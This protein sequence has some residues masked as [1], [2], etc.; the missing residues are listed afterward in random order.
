[1]LPLFDMLANAQNGR[2][3]ELIARQFE[4]NRQQMELAM[5][6]LLPAFSVGLKR[7]VSDPYGVGAF[8]NGQRDLL[9]PLVAGASRHDGTDGVDAVGNGHYATNH[10]EPVCC[11]HGFY[12][13]FWFRKRG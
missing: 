12:S 6:A 3:M 13:L 7:N 4:L 8:L 10:H 2:G 9:H 1:M 11:S 5:E